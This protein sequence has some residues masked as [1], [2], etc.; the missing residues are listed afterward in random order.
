MESNIS[1]KKLVQEDL[2]LL[3]KWRNQDFVKE[4]FKPGTPTM[5]EINEIYLPR[6]AGEK[7]TF[8][9]IIYID[10]ISAGLIQTYQMDDYP[11]Y[12]KAIGYKDNAVSIDLFI[13]NKN[14]LHKGYGKLIIA[15]FLKEIAFN[16]F[17]LKKCLI[18][19]DPN[20][21]AA[22]K[23]YEKVGFRHLQT[24]KNEEDGNIE[25][26]MELV[27]TRNTKLSR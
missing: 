24:V 8:C 1:F 18:A 12:K 22:I 25:Y 2:P 15:K 10:Q 16:K 21:L 26:L 5:K 19:P 27:K 4:W 9:Y 17:G 3:L 6:I 13:G 20:N 23:A 11:E 7:P 14:F